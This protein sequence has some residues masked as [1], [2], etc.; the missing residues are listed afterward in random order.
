MTVV[1]LCTLGLTTSLP[2]TSHK[3]SSSK[4]PFINSCLHKLMSLSNRTNK[5]SA[6][7]LEIPPMVDNS[8]LANTKK[9]GSPEGSRVHN[10]RFRQA[11]LT[12]P[13]ANVKAW[14]ASV[15]VTLIR[16]ATSVEGVRSSGGVRCCCCVVEVGVEEGEEFPR[17]TISN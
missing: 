8:L 14:R 15:R 4:I 1:F 17:R 9:G 16:S 7:S 11:S 13:P 10:K 6:S 2:S 12:S 5:A 3:I